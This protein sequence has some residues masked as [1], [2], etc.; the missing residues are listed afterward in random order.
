M[1]FPG[2]S[3]VEESRIFDMILGRCCDEVG[4]ERFLSEADEEVCEV[5]LSND[6]IHINDSDEVLEVKLPCFTHKQ[7]DGYNYIEK[8]SIIYEE[9]KLNKRL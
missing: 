1:C 5:C 4:G 2:I 8:K 7:W 6:V 3:K 9:L